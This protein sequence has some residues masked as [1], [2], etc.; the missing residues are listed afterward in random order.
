MLAGL[1]VPPDD[2]DKLATLVRAAGADALADR[3]EVALDDD[4]ALFALTIDERAIILAA[5]KDPQDG[6]V[7]LRAVL[8]DRARVASTRGPRSV[9]DSAGSLTASMRLLPR[10]AVAT[11]LGMS[12]YRAHALA[13][14]A[15]CR[16]TAVEEGADEE[17]QPA[18]TLWDWLQLLIVPAILIAVTFAWSAT[19]TRSDNKREDR[20]IAADRAA[21]EEAR[22]DATLQAYLDQMSGLMLDKKLLTSKAGDAVRAVARTV[23]LAALRR[24]DG[25]RR[26]EVVRFLS[27]ARLSAKDRS[28]LVDLDGA[29]LEGADLGGANLRG[30]NLEAANLDG[31]QPQG[32]QPRGRQPHAAP[33]SG[34]PTSGAPTSRDADLEDADLGGANLRDANLEA[35]RR[36]RGRRPQG[37]Q[38]QGRQPR[39]APTS[40][41]P[42]SRAPT[43]RAPTS[44]APTSTTGAPTSGRRPQGRQPHGRRPRGR[45]S[46][47]NLGGANLEGRQE[48][49]SRQVHRRTTSRRSRRRFSTRKRRFSTRC[50][51]RSWRSST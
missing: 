9:R 31:R 24:L 42:T 36:P 2:V 11:G 44:G 14:V 20:R 5:L 6:L 35:Q 45:D 30:A 22:Q 16:R 38:P 32:R 8:Q 26:G 18:K 25:E 27:E 7:E 37:R 43:S 3:L 19:Q 51:R 13:G 34:A 15:R 10:T 29:D 28:P 23:T 40:G 33:T 46:N 4:V 49:K 1:P 39:A 41:A 47:A 12:E 48:P 17:V 21:A 50:P